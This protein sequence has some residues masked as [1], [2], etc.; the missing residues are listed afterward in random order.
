MANEKP[1][2]TPEQVEWFEKITKIIRE[3]D[4]EI[5]AG[6]AR[7]EILE[8]SRA[9][10]DKTSE[11]LANKGDERVLQ[12]AVDEQIIFTQRKIN[13]FETLKR[14]LNLSGICP[15]CSGTG[16][17]YLI[18][19]SRPLNELAPTCINC[20]GSGWKDGNK[21]LFNKI[22]EDVIRTHPDGL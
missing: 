11:V 22:V 3:L 4:P 8:L 12:T 15:T 6:L 10:I 18:K 17:H 1:K 19:P 7:K 9:Q 5:Q 13:L 16:T 14:R 21:N 2:P 20:W